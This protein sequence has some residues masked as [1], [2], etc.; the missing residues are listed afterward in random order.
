MIQ[1]AQ[2]HIPTPK[3]RMTVSYTALHLNGHQIHVWFRFSQL[4]FQLGTPWAWRA[5]GTGTAGSVSFQVSP[6]RVELEPQAERNS[7]LGWAFFLGGGYVFLFTPQKIKINHFSLES[8]R[9]SRDSGFFGCL[10]SIRILLQRT[11][12]P[13]RCNA[14]GSYNGNT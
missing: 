10:G 14:F 9:N 7:W 11:M 4:S 5:G 6:G 1:G 3:I 8:S 2:S 13:T 12:D